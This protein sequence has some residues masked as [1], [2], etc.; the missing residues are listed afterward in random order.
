[1][2]GV[3][4]LAKSNVR[5]S[6]QLRRRSRRLSGQLS[7]STPHSPAGT[8]VESNSIGLSLQ[9]AA[10][11]ADRGEFL[12]AP[13]MIPH[14][15]MKESGV[16]EEKGSQEHDPESQPKQRKARK[17]MPRGSRKGQP[18]G[19]SL[20]KPLCDLGQE[21]KHSQTRPRR[22]SRLRASMDDIKQSSSSGRTVQRKEANRKQFRSGKGL[23]AV[24][25]SRCEAKDHAQAKKQLRCVNALGTDVARSLTR[26][27]LITFVRP[28]M[29]E[30]YGRSHAGD[31]FG[32][33]GD[34]AVVAVH[35]RL[36]G[37][38]SSDSDSIPDAAVD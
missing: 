25:T 37:V 16:E 38:L 34:Y 5:P 8:P 6:P 26:T 17:G 29:L 20:S 31:S 3:Y 23:G 4:G 7:F 24:H 18:S 11:E 28:S 35:D 9:T 27:S 19:T 21:S 12:L 13:S 1:M 2:S 32:A 10:P 22:S 15:Q 33:R 30:E 14:Q 36:I